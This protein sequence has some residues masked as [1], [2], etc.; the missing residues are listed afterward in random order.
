MRASRNARRGRLVPEKW[1]LA[2]SGKP[3]TIADE[4]ARYSLR[5]V[6]TPWSGADDGTYV[7]RPIHGHKKYQVE[8]KSVTKRTGRENAGERARGVRE[9]TAKREANRRDPREDRGHREIQSGTW[10]RGKHKV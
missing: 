1:L 7:Y 5:R 10:Q 4:L 3:R 8:K 9:I 6:P 2:N